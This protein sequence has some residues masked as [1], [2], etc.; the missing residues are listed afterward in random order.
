M[1]TMHIQ[2]KK[3][4]QMA[5]AMDKSRFQSATTFSSNYNK[6]IAELWIPNRWI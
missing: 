2:I 1:N 3:E 4:R 6:S 5:S